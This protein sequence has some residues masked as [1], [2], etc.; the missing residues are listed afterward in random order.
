[1][2]AAKPCCIIDFP[3]AASVNDSYKENILLQFH[4]KLAIHVLF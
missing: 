1:M 2:K 3:F 4:E